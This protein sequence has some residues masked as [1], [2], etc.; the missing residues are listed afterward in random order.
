MKYSKTLAKG[1]L[2]NLQETEGRQRDTKQEQHVMLL[3]PEKVLI[4]I[5]DRA[6]VQTDREAAVMITKTD[7]VRVIKEMIKTEGA[8]TG[9]TEVQ[10]DSRDRRLGII[11]DSL[12]QNLETETENK[13]DRALIDK[14]V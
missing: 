12:D 5:G 2:E 1:T 8:Q 13:V 11:P 14:E 10:T 6:R 3:T 4:R 9:A 7:I